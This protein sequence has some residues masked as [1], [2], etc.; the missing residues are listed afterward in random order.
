VQSL[1]GLDLQNTAA[2]HQNNQPMDTLIHSQQQEAQR[3]TADNTPA[4]AS[5]VSSGSYFPLFLFMCNILTWVK[6]S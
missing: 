6:S 2:P 3:A 1:T 5:K 4:A